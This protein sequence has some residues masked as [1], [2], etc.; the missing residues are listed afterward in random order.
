MDEPVRRRGRFIFTLLLAVMTMSAGAHGGNGASWQGTI[1]CTTTIASGY[2]SLAVDAAGSLAELT[3]GRPV[4]PGLRIA[5]E[6]ASI[7]RDG[8]SVSAR[9]TGTVHVLRTTRRPFLVR[10]RLIESG[11]SHYRFYRDGRPWA[12]PVAFDDAAAASVARLILSGRPAQVTLTLRSGHLVHIGPRQAPLAAPA[13]E[14]RAKAELERL[15]RLLG[16]GNSIAACTQLSTD[17]LLIH[18]G[19][20]GCLIAFESAKFLYRDRYIHASVTDVALFD[21]DHHSYALATIERPRGYAR[22]ILIHEHG[23]Y[24]YL[25]DL[26]LSPIELW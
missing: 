2:R 5:V 17:A 12:C 16:R 4:A 20:D 3:L 10:S 6:D 1:L 22:A 19:P 7:A 11:Y 8:R 26:D 24:R 15:L 18:G 13:K 14:R 21:L 23:T 25:G 9:A